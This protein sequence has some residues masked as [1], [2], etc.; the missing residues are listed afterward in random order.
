MIDNDD[1]NVLK[2]FINEFI[3]E[4]NILQKTTNKFEEK[5]TQILDESNKSKNNLKYLLL[6]QQVQEKV[7]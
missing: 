2:D 7:H 3:E 6:D 5:R 1:N 4:E